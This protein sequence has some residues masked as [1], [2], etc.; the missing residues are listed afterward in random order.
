MKEKHLTVQ[1]D[2]L[3]NMKEKLQDIC[4]YSEKQINGNL[5]QLMYIDMLS[6]EDEEYQRMIKQQNR[7]LVVDAILDDK[8]E[9]LNIFRENQVTDVSSKY[10]PATTM[11]IISPKVMQISMTAKKF[12]TY[13]KLWNEIVDFLNKNTQNPKNIKQRSQN[14]DYKLTGDY[15]TDHKKIISKILMCSS[16]IAMDGRIGPAKSILYGKNLIPYIN[17]AINQFGS[18]N[19]NG[20]VA[21][22]SDLVDDDKVIVC[23]SNNSDQSGL[24]LIDDQQNGQYFF[25][26]TTNWN[27]QYCWFRIM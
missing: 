5:T 17:Y 23:R 26:Q 21:H 1:L 10:N 8:V 27:K 4:N 6:S 14:L 11:G 15:E 25:N 2:Y 20:L 9:E 19:I 16:I 22:Q 18:N 12:E 13:Q 3:D 7:E 24:L